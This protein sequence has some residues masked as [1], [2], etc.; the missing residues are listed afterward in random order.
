MEKAKQKA[1]SLVG[2]GYLYGAKG[3]ICSEAFRAQQ[4]RQYP[5][6]AKNILET[7]AKWD[8][9]PVWDCAQL[10]RAV[11]AAAG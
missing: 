1:L 4:A 5:E 11:A 7:G 8:G 2:Q 3:Q 9:Q 10:T 6:Q